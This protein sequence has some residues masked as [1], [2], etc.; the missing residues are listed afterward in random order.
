[1]F[2]QRIQHSM[3]LCVCMCVYLGGSKLAPES[4]QMMFAKANGKIRLCDAY[5]IHTH[6][7]TLCIE[8]RSSYSH[9][10]PARVF[11]CLFHHIFGAYTM[12]VCIM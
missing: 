7:T 12:C 6:N 11:D 8:N 4:R 3:Y 10:K 1:M 9:N 2:V 5:T